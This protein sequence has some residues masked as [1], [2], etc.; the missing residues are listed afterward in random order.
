MA[1]PLPNPA[2]LE[3]V[4]EQEQTQ[5]NAIRDLRNTNG[6]EFCKGKLRK[7]VQPSPLPLP[8]SEPTLCNEQ[9]WQTRASDQKWRDVIESAHK[10]NLVGLAFSGGGIRSATFNLGVLQALADLK[11]LYRIDYLSTVSGGGYIGGWLAAWTKRLKSFAKVQNRLS[12]NRVHHEEDMEPTPIRFLR[13]FSNYLTPRLG[14]FSGDAWTMGAIYLRNLLLNLTVVLAIV[15]T[16]LLLTRVVQRWALAANCTPGVD[17]GL[18]L[19]VAVLLLIAFLLILINMGYLDSLD[20][21]QCGKGAP[22]LTEQSWILL[23]VCA[24]LFA[25]A[26]LAAL[27]PTVRLQGA[28]GNQPISYL[29]AL[30]TAASAYGCL[31]LV[32]TLGGQAYRAWLAEWFSGI[33]DK[34]ANLR[35]RYRPQPKPKNTGTAA[36]SPVQNTPQ[37]SDRSK[38]LWTGMITALGAG[39]LAGCLYTLLSRL[40]VCWQMRNVLTVGVPLVVGIFILAGVLHIGLMGVLFQ[41]WKREW[42]GRLGGWLLLSGIA[43]FAIFWMALCFPDFIR[44][45][46]PTWKTIAAKYL[47]PAWVLS[48]AGSVLAGKSSASGK[49]GTQ[50][51]VDVVAKVGPY[52]FMGGLL[53]WVSWGIDSILRDNDRV[54]TALIVCALVALVMAWRVDI[55]QFSMHLF[56]R[57]RL[58]RCY[59]GASN[60][61]RSPNRFT[62]FDPGD[63]IPLK[64]FTPQAP[65]PYD[66][67]YPVLNASLNL[68][69]GKD[70]AW[71]E[72]KAES[73]VM[74]P[75]YCGYD[76]WLEEQD[77]PMLMRERPMTDKELSESD[78]KAKVQAQATHEKLV[79][80]IG[81]WVQPKLRRL[82][83]NLDRFGYRPTGDYAFPFPYHG[84][85]L[86][87]A[88]AISGAAASPNMGY[89]SSA[90][91]AF[92]M[93]VFNVRLGQWM[94]NPR[95]RRTWRRP[96]P[97]LGL[98]CLLREL[99]AGT[100]DEAA[101][102]YL[103]D[104]GHFENL[105]LYELVK[106][107]C[108]LIIVCDAE[109][110]SP[111][112]FGGLGNAIRKCRIDLGVDIKLDVSEISPAKSARI[113]KKHY[114]V[115]EIHYENADLKAPVGTLVYFKA[116]LTGDE[117]TDV[118]N[119][120][121]RNTSF[122]HESTVDQWFSESQFESYRQLGYHAVWSSIR[123]TPRTIPQTAPHH[124]WST[125]VDDMRASLRALA[126][127][128]TRQKKETLEEKSAEEP[129]RPILVDFGFDTSALD[130]GASGSPRTI[131]EK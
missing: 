111:Y 23:A 3:T 93:T 27:W 24:P 84:P 129:L 102:V 7:V 44:N 115:G 80:R 86:G 42:W 77:S 66:G 97:Q 46:E 128:A 104:G 61:G 30:I 19:A 55:N 2:P 59:L 16:W 35:G 96:T 48:T 112:E 71:Q 88:M 105:G 22:H 67:P 94:G 34:I 13:M 109:A 39:L 17:L 89:Y 4:L 119:Y 121:K 87:L 14:L 38:E 18:R 107:R 74:T 114:A 116:S 91:V 9:K 100:D 58:V 125:V 69:K 32:A 25:A 92:L 68:V 53:C 120:K 72:R 28:G 15:A 83:R 79:K 47:T 95:H 123:A 31:W 65:D 122:P 8:G 73:F 64:D 41:D 33:A 52:V 11:L 43:W 101:Y 12:T 127:D 110:D 29:E 126:S 70:L 106:R 99:F 62:G 131:P 57:N 85:N 49:P 118:T 82:L 1:D 98:S 45:D 117:P 54:Y 40:T 56:Y 124:W 20:K 36:G 76:V 103:S 78:D 37:T 63:D 5:I 50:T 108:G 81:T 6:K 21:K 90:P 75:C 26:I 10:G 51:W 60:E 130:E 113:S